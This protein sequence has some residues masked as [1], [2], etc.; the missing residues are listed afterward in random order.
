MAVFFFIGPFFL[1][2][3]FL[4][5]IA[6]LIGI[7]YS[8]LGISQD[9]ILQ[10]DVTKGIRGRI[11]ATKEFVANL[12]FVVWAVMVGVLSTVLDPIMIIRLVGIVLSVIVVFTIFIYRSIPY[13]VRSKL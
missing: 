4:Y 7:I 6:L 11:F 8:F 2:P 1:S 3:V 9:T 13:E 12:T 5:I 10:E